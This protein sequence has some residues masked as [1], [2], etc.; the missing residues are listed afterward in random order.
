MKK[1]FA[2]LVLSTALVGCGSTNIGTTTN[3]GTEAASPSIESEVAEASQTPETLAEDGV[4]G[5]RFKVEFG[6]AEKVISEYEEDDLLMVTYTFTN[7]SE[8]TVSADTALMIQGFQDGIEVDRTFDSTL[9]GDNESKSIK[10]GA[11][12]ECKALFKLSS[13]SEL[14]VEATEFLGMDGSMVTKTYTIQ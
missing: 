2:L 10:P 11:S 12:L 9:T 8:E 6:A 4:L 1:I 7:N 5:G 3:Q 13:T 14:E